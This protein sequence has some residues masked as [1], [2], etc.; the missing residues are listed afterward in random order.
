MIVLSARRSYLLKQFDTRNRAGELFKLDIELS[1]LAIHGAASTSARTL[2]DTFPFSIFNPSVGVDF[3]SCVGIHQN[4]FFFSLLREKCL[5]SE[6]IVTKLIS[7][8]IYVTIKKHLTS[9][10][11]YFKYSGAYYIRYSGSSHNEIFIERVII[12]KIG[13]KMGSN[14]RD[15]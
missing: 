8:E 2:P 14:T 15:I 6:N 13:Y 1:F 11:I 7:I 10:R 5:Y 9:N 12:L 4:P 3:E